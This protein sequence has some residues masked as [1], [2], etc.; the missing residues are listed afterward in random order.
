MPQLTVSVLYN[1]KY[2]AHLLFSSMNFVL[3]NRLAIALLL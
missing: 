2:Q 3:T 1:Q